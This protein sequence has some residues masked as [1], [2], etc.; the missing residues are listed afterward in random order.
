MFSKGAG[1]TGPLHHMIYLYSE[2]GSCLAHVAG[3]TTLGP[4]VNASPLLAVGEENG[5]NITSCSKESIASDSCGFR[6]P[7]WSQSLRKAIF[8]IQGTGCTGKVGSCGAS[9][10]KRSEQSNQPVLSA[11]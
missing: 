2:L 6:L 10:E 5:A 3:A 8:E 9:D 4:L 7:T 1:P 11:G